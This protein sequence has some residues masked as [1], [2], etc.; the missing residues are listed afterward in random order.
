M[1]NTA[2]L[3]K[4]LIKYLMYDKAMFFSNRI[5]ETY[6]RKVFNAPACQINFLKQRVTLNQ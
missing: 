1:T 2:I 3:Q 4:P 5:N 6:A